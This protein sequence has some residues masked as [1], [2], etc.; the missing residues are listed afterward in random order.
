M[1]QT[2]EY[3]FPGSTAL[4]HGE[5]VRIH[6]HN[7]DG[8]VTHFG[9]RVRT[10]ALSELAP[11][12]EGSLF[13]RWR[14]ER[15]AAGAEGEAFTPASDVAEDYRTWLTRAEHGDAYPVSDRAFWRMM[16]EAGFGATRGYWRAPGDSHAR[17]RVLF[18]L[19]LRSAV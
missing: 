2:A 1:L 9:E 19:A 10:T 15:I 16:R 12:P 11:P 8:T 4:F 3:P 5:L 6:Q 14:A 7:A 13:D 18:R 17:T